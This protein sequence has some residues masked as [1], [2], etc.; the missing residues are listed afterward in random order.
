MVLLCLLNISCVFNRF[1]YYQ[2]QFTCS[3]MIL[4]KKRLTMPHESEQSSWAVKSLS[5]RRY[6]N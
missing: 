6:L 1:S 4:Q 5:S 3:I 2:S